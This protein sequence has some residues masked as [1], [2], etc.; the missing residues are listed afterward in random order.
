MHEK[1]YEQRVNGTSATAKSGALIN[2]EI[3]TG[4]AVAIY[5][6][7]KISLSQMIDI[8]PGVRAEIYSFER[9]ILREASLD[10]SKTATNSIRELIPGIGMNFRPKSTFNLFAGIHRGYAPPRI[11]DAID[12]SLTN[13]VLD[14][15]A[16]KSWNTEVGLR[17][18]VYQGFYAELTYFHMNFDNQII[19]SSQ[20]VGGSGFGVTNA[21]RTLHKGVEASVNINSREMFGSSWLFLFDVNATYTKATYNSDRLVSNGNEDINVR[22]NRLPY[23]PQFTTSSSFTIETNFGTGLRLT[24]TLIGNQYTDEV[25]TKSPTNN[26]RIGEMPSYT[27]LDATLYHHLSAIDA[28]FKLCVKNLL[29]ERYITTRRPEGIRVGLPRFI[30]VGFEIKL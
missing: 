12:F 6:L 27:I 28:S 20:S 23:A 11:K 25:N 22:G 2:D 5:V 9:E 3:R 13:P 16:E 26:G 4:N 18:Q 24:N 10:V 14:L 17:T 8:T 1:A 21:G 7:D 29:D 15:K 30:T 19:P